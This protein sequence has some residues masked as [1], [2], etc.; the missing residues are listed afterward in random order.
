[1]GIIVLPTF[2][3]VVLIAREDILKIIVPLLRLLRGSI[4]DLA[5]CVGYL[6]ENVRHKAA[7]C[8]LDRP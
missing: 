1:M 3:A 5:T 6:A 8:F 7:D 4:D 2:S